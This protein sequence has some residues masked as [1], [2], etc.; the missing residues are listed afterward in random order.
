MS[1]SWRGAARRR[2][3]DIQVCTCI[4]GGDSSR[5]AKPCKKRFMNHL[6]LLK[7]QAFLE[8]TEMFH[9]SR[10]SRSALENLR[11]AWRHMCRMFPQSVIPNALIEVSPHSRYDGFTFAHY[12]RFAQK[13]NELS[14][15][16]RL[17]EPFRILS[18]ADERRP[19]TLDLVARA[20]RL[21]ADRGA[22]RRLAR[23]AGVTPIT[24]WR[25]IHTATKPTNQRTIEKIWQWVQAHEQ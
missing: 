6:D 10:E 9:Q 14:R 24:V 3:L 12:V 5:T 16:H 18:E 21:C 17:P 25:W 2:G 22:Q 1:A 15:G 8:W 4:F 23:Y 19:P 11:E 20:A 13:M 7:T